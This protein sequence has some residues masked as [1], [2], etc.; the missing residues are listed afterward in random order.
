[1]SL[2]A[3]IFSVVL[4]FLLSYLLS[5]FTG[6]VY[7]SVTGSSGGSY[8]NLSPLVGLPISYIFFLLAIF[9][10]FWGRHKYWWIGILIIPAVVFEV[11]F[12]FVHIYIPVIVGIL[13]WIAGWGILK[14]KTIVLKNK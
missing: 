4:V 12:D 9:V 6:Q 11:Y 14:L 8:I 2:V 1:M 7:D 10:A 13:G 5:P 3:N